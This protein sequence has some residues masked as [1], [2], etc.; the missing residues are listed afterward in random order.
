MHA[1]IR[2]YRVS[3]SALVSDKVNASFVNAIR[4]VPGFIRY[5]AIDQG[6]GWWASVS[7]FETR[8]G[9]AQSNRLAEEW[10]KANVAN[11]VYSVNPE[12]TEGPVVVA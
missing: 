5:I 8:D 4:S 3:N 9:V 7:V 10:V 1:S 11:L 12:I 2:R 6:D